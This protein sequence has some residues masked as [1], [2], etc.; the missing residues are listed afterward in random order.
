MTD[1][2]SLEEITDSMY[3]AEAYIPIIIRVYI[4][5]VC[6]CVFV[7]TCVLAH[8]LYLYHS[9]FKIL[10]LSKYSAIVDLHKIFNKQFVGIFTT[11]LPTYLSPYLEL[12]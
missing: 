6:V 5:C 4:V 11:D 3:R 8:M 12:E 9:N 1:H 2:I 10:T 7:C